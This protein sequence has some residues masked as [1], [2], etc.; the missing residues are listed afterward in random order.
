MHCVRIPLPGGGVAIVCGA[1]KRR[2]PCDCGRPHTKLCDYV[3]SKTLDGKEIT[4]DAKLC[5]MCAFM[6][7]EKDFCW[8]H[9]GG[10]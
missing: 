7:G 3:L 1:K 2:S 10:E 9:R 5:A 8:K 4:C 6:V